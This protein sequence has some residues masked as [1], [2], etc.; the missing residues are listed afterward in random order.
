MNACMW[1]PLDPD[2]RANPVL[3]LGLAI[4]CGYSASGLPY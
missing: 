2:Y 4:F 1:I 3:I